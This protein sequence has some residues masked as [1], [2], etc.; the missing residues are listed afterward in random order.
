MLAVLSSK[1]KSLLRSLFTSLANSLMSNV[2]FKTRLVFSIMLQFSLSMTC[3]VRLTIPAH[4]SCRYTSPRRC[5]MFS[6]PTFGDGPTPSH[7]QTILYWGFAHEG[8]PGVIGGGVHCGKFSSAWC[9]FIRNVNLS[10]FTVRS[11]AEPGFPSGRSSSAVGCH[12]F[13]MGKCHG[14]ALC[15]S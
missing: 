9:S 11:V 6:S 2:C 4:H 7:A 12:G 10:S 8:K 14:A 5:G 13:A 15:A 1:E 3:W